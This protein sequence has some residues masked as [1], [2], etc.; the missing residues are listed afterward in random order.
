MLRPQTD[1]KM[2]A[3]SIPEGWDTLV[4]ELSDFKNAHVISKRQWGHSSER[5]LICSYGVVV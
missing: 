4:P 1:L 2:N 5:I 3:G